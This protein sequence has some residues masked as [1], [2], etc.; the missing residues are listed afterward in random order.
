[1]TSSSKEQTGKI[2]VD[3]RQS[4][5]FS[6]GYLMNFRTHPLA[7]ILLISLAFL[8]L[9]G[10]E[11]VSERDKSGA[12]PHHFRFSLFSYNLRSDGK[13]CKAEWRKAP[14]LAPS[15]WRRIESRYQ[16][17]NSTTNARIITERNWYT[18]HQA[19]LNRV[20]ARSSRYLRHVADQLEARNLPGE[21]ALLP[22]V[23]SAYNPFA[24]STSNAS[25][26][27]QFI[28]STAKHLKMD[29]NW[30][31][32]AR[33][34][35]PAATNKALDYLVFL[36]NHYDGDWLKAL[37][38]YNAGWGTIDKAVAKNRARGLPTDYWSLDVPAETAAYVPKL[39][40]LAQIS[41]HPE[42]YGINW[43]YV[44][45]LPYFAEVHF[46]GQIDVGFA[47]D[48]AKVDSDELHMLNPGISRWA[49]PPG[50]P[51]RLLVPID[52]ANDLQERIANMSSSDLMPNAGSDSSDTFNPH[53]QALEEKSARTTRTQSSASTVT[54]K[55]R[56][57]NSSGRSYTVKAGDTL[58]SISRQI[59]ITPDA[60]R[61]LNKLSVGEAL[62]PGQKISLT[63]SS[64]SYASNSTS[65]SSTSK[66]S[67]A[68]HGRIS[69][70]F[71]PVSTDKESTSTK[72]TTVRA[73]KNKAT[74]YTVKSGDTLMAIS[75]KYNVKVADILRWNS[76]S[77]NNTA[78]K[79]GQRINLYLD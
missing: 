60:L 45:D 23:E 67:S 1:M 50:G 25:G 26:L 5:A 36:R 3:N 44:P 28:P 14:P 9:T 78:I 49:T 31:Y 37:A 24:I 38:A 12:S 54:S 53:V 22:I 18:S 74:A 55:H 42:I 17:P 8:A 68:N 19:Y 79:P 57:S 41:Q 72:K 6:C 43:A 35:I 64:A 10:C 62:R 51:Y 39:L 30:W 66:K 47:A 63:G 61:K 15:L 40:A 4:T 70:S 59:G 29:M 13:Q 7:R 21:L 69:Q 65:K 52:Q 32:D 11:S 34:D 20:S 58:W 75:R 33:R 48:L 77:K 2:G 76:L 27:W 71:S 73:N 46:S 16:L 56:S